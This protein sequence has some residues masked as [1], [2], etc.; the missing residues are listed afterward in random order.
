MGRFDALTQIEEPKKPMPQLKVTPPPPAKQSAKPASPPPEAKKTTKPQNR[1]PS[2]QSPSLGLS[3]KVEK[4]TTL[5][6]PSLAKK[7]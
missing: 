2:M 4:H 7:V 5:I 6:L 3:E 1:L